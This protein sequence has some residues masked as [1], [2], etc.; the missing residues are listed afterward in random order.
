MKKASFFLFFL[1]GVSFLSFSQAPAPADFFAGKWA[2]EIL[3]TPNGDAKMTANL[4]RKD[5]K[6]TGTLTNTAEGDKSEPIPITS[7]EEG[8]DK[9]TLG[10]TT[11]GYDLTMQL[12]K[13]D[14]DHLKGMLIDQFE[15]K[16]TRLKE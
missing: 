3:G 11:Q 16:A 5:G 8:T 7:I 14:D 2:I 4:V 12:N 13:V 10:F 15:T 9:L 6:L 1:L